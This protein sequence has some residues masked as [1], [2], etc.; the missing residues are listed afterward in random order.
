MSELA[1]ALAPEMVGLVVTPAVLIA[2]LV[3]L[4]TPRPIGKLA[5]FAAVYLSVYAVLSLVVVVIGHVAGI[6]G[7]SASVIRGW[8]SLTVGVLFLVGGA[9]AWRGATRPRPGARSSQPAP[10]WAGG[11]A[12]PH[13]RLLVLTALALAV[14][15]PNVAILLSGLGIIVTA[16]VSVGAQLVGVGLMLAACLVDF[17]VPALVY[18]VGGP[19]GRGRLQAASRWMVLHNQAIGVGVLVFFG[20]LFAGR[21]IAQIA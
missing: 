12:D 19:A 3:V 16:D 9:I 11:L 18:A 1:T 17:A 4:G 5:L 2:C 6:E 13:P 20:L 10:G 7:H 15:N 14:I 8:I 21:G